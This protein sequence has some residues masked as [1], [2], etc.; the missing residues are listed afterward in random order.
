M[1]IIVA[2]DQPINIQVVKQ[3]LDDKPDADFRASYFANGQ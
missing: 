3:M 1:Q 2:D